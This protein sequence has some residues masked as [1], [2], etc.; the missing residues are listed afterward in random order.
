MRAHLRKCST[1]A[2]IHTSSVCAGYTPNTHQA[3]SASQALIIITDEA[4]D[5]ATEHEE[6]G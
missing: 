2:R 6:G 1:S 5:A 3:W 4:S